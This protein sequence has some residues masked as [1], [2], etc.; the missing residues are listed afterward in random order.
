M[1]RL[2]DIS[3]NFAIIENN[4]GFLRMVEMDTSVH[5]QNLLLYSSQYQLGSH[6]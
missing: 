5:S 6:F 3:A 4:R 1:E 2:W